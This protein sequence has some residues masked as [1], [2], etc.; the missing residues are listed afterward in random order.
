MA[1][2]ELT[3]GKV[4]QVPDELFEEL[5]SVKWYAPCPGQTFYAARNVGLPNGKRGQVFLHNVIWEMLNGPIPDGYTVDHRDR[6]GLNNMPDNFRLA[7]RYSRV[8]IGGGRV[9]TLLDSLVF[10]VPVGSTGHK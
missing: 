5:N 8:P 2:I 6:D 7:T 10:L 9:I 1:T 4:T 3:Q